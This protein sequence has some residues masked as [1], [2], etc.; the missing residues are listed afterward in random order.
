MN[1]VRFNAGNES[2]HI[3]FRTETY[4]GDFKLLGINFDLKFRMTSAV[5]ECVVVCN[6]KL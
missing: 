2:L 1:G 5:Y 3:L 6:W 4:G